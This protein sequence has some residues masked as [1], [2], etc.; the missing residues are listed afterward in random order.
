MSAKYLIYKYDYSK[1]QNFLI[2]DYKDNCKLNK[3]I[4]TYT[5]I[6]IQSNS[7]IFNVNGKL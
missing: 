4:W 5:F 7:L 2:G 3:N 1:S 6:T